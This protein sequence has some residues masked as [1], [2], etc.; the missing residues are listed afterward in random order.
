MSGAGGHLASSEW[1]YIGDTKDY[2]W[3]KYVPDRGTKHRSTPADQELHRP[4]QAILKPKNLPKEVGLRERDRRWR[5]WLRNVNKVS[6]SETDL[7]DLRRRGLTDA[8]VKE[9]LF[10][11]VGQG[12]V[13][14]VI[15]YH[16]LIVGA[17]VR[18][19]DCPSGGRYRWWKLKGMAPHVKGQLPIG[20]YGK[21]ND[22]W[23]VEGYLKAIVASF[24]LG[25]KFVGFGSVAQLIGSRDLI[26]ET[27]GALGNQQLLLRP[28]LA[29]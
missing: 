27:L 20:V 7:A 21:G 22:V 24:K 23:L 12:Y 11:S 3:G 9:S 8:Q 5:E 19:R 15:D 18:L 28:M 2:L 25:A 26:K 1:R 29:A 4:T 17:Q 14:P 10:R 6:Q 13:I 16:G